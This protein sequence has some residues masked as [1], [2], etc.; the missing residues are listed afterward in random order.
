MNTVQNYSWCFYEFM[1]WHNADIEFWCLPLIYEDISQMV[2]SVG[3]NELFSKFSFAKKK[4]LTM[5]CIE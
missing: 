2:T 3:I 5:H 1:H 4:I